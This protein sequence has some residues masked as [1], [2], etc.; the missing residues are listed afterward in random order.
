MI[1]PEFL[2]RLYANKR[3]LYDPNLLDE[4][5]TV[6]LSHPSP[7]ELPLNTVQIKQLT[8]IAS[9]VINHHIQKATGAV[10]KDEALMRAFAY[11]KEG[12]RR[13]E[14]G[15]C[16]YEGLNPED[17]SVIMMHRHFLSHGADFLSIVARRSKDLYERKQLMLLALEDLLASLEI[18]KDLADGSRPLNHLLISNLYEHLIALSIEEDLRTYR[19]KAIEHKL[20]AAQIHQDD[21]KSA[22][23]YTETAGLEHIA[24]QDEPFEKRKELL[25]AAYEH[26]HNAID[27]TTEE[28][29]KKMIYRHS[30]AAEIAMQMIHLAGEK[31]RTDWIFKR[32]YDLDCLAD[33]CR[34][35]DP[36]RAAQDY[37]LAI[38]LFFGIAR[39]EGTK[40]S[41]QELGESMS[42][43]AK[44]EFE[45]LSKVNPLLYAKES[46]EVAGILSRV[47]DSTNDL[48]FGREALE[49]YQSSNTYFTQHPE[50]D[51]K[52]Y[53]RRSTNAMRW[54][55]MQK[56]P[57]QGKCPDRTFNSKPKI[58]AEETIKGQ[59]N[60]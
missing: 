9:Y 18:G 49:Y 38:S 51:K 41:F 26:I 22:I 46:F 23:A 8:K 15:E 58:S 47:Y 10:Y 28:I 57:R 35:E 24:A 37:R 20:I 53:A 55:R 14:T 42:I 48:R 17:P 11:C 56:K 34:E 21:N 29:N 45:A 2:H 25:S 13:I 12:A 60:S 54:L 31:E 7:K 16:E 5:H 27:K 4:V 19:K 32:I 52:E 6:F 50:H 33:R 3:K 1:T 30:L 36:Q 43:I 44:K 39:K 40:E 59:L